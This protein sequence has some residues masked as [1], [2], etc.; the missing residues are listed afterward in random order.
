MTI[1]HIDQSGVTTCYCYWFLEGKP[2]QASLVASALVP[3]PKPT[4][5]DEDEDAY[6]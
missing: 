3:A 4:D 2:Q 5:E 1:T 6:E